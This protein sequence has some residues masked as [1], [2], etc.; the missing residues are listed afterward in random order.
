MDQ[1][2]PLRSFVAVIECG[3]LTAAAQKL[4]V[5]KSIV[6]RQISQ[7]ENQLGARLLQR[8]TRKLFPTECGQVYYQRASQILADLDEANQLVS[9]MQG[10]PRGRLRVTAP[11]SY[12]ISHLSPIISRFIHDYPQL[13]L[14]LSLSDHYVD[15]IE[16][17]FDVALRIGRMEN[18]S[19]I[20]R[21][22]GELRT[23]LCGSPEYFSHHPI[24]TH[25]Q[26]LPDH[27]CLGHIDFR[28]QEWSFVDEN[29]QPISLTIAP[30][31]RANNGDCLRQFAL[32]GLGLVKIPEFFVKDDLESGQLIAVLE[33]FVRQDGGIY[34]VYPHQRHLS[35]KV[36]CFIDY[37]IN[38]LGTSG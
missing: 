19:L 8:T 28:G 33:K 22:L 23:V 25:P 34:A 14:D 27:Q 20:A 36:R 12:G 38:N 32:N 1:F 11:I 10:I 21:R 6:S 35:P 3:S 4:G 16:S 18:S 17:G 15:L 9:H 5:A 31:I 37:L 26:D 24:P 29:G 7:L 13:E 30:R 2:T